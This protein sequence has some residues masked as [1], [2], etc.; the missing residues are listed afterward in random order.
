MRREREGEERGKAKR[1]EK[2]EKET[3]TA[4]AKSVRASRAYRISH[5][6]LD[7]H[8]VQLRE[9]HTLLGAVPLVKP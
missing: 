3:E 1:R 9:D 6:L 4:C 8:G 7:S 5:K 2:R